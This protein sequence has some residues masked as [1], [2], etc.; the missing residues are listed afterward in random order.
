MR[1]ILHHWLSSSFTC[2]TFLVP[3]QF[4]RGGQQRLHNSWWWLQYQM[5]LWF[6]IRSNNR[7]G[8]GQVRFSPRHQHVTHN[9]WWWA[10]RVFVVLN[11]WVTILNKL[12]CKVETKTE[13]WKH[14]D[15]IIKVRAGYHARCAWD[16]KNLLTS[17]VMMPKI[18]VSMSW[19]SFWRHRW[20]HWGNLLLCQ[21]YV[22]IIEWSSYKVREMISMLKKNKCPH[23]C[24]SD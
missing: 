9:S 12:N 24:D 23:T 10:Y 20:F 14:I 11:H 16:C 8:Y 5:C 6:G 17:Q 7:S 22:I 21:A 19:I 13:T 2:S 4:L 1:I 15:G 18:H 3:C